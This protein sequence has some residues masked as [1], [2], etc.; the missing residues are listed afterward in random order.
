MA[1]SDGISIVDAFTRDDE[2]PMTDWSSLVGG[3]AVVS[4]EAEPTDSGQNLV[5]YDDDTFGPDVEVFIQ[6]ED[7]PSANDSLGLV[8]GI[9]SGSDGYMLHWIVRSGTDELEIYRL[10]GGSPTQ[11]SGDVADEY[12]QFEGLGLKLTD[13]NPEAWRNDGGG[14]D[15]IATRT[16]G[17]HDAVAWC[18]MYGWDASGTVDDFSAG[19]PAAA[20]PQTVTV[21]DI[22]SA[23][24]FGAPTI[25][26]GAVTIVAPGIATAE[27]MGAPTITV[28]AATINPP[29]IA[30]AEA[31]G[32]P[33]ISTGAVTVVVP[34]I[35][36]A[37]AIG[38]PTISATNTINPPG[39]A[40]AEAFGA[41]T[42]TTGVATVNPPGITSDEAIGAPTITTGGVTVN[43][44]GIATAEA[45]GAPTVATSAQAVVVDGIATGE[46]IGAPTITPGA[47]TVNPPGI[48]SA[49][50]IGAPTISTGAVTVSPAGI[51]TA[52]ATGE[53]TISATATINPPGIA[54]DEAIGAPTITTGSVTV[55]PAGI[56]SAEAIGAPTVGGG[57]SVA[58]E[59][60][61]TAEATGAV[62]ITIG[63]APVNPVGIASSETMG[64]P[65]VDV[66]VGP[67]VAGP[68][69]WDVLADFEEGDYSDFTGS[70]QSWDQEESF[71]SPGNPP[72]GW[73]WSNGWDDYLD[74]EEADLTDFD[75]TTDTGGSLNAAGDVREGVYGMGFV[76][77]DAGVAYGDKNLAAVNQTSFITA[78]SLKVD[79]GFAS[80]VS[81]NTWVFGAYDGAGQS[82]ALMSIYNDGGTYKFR[83]T[84]RNDSDGTHTLTDYTPTPGTFYDFI[85]TWI[86]GDGTGQMKVYINGALHTFK[87]DVDNDTK[88]VDLTRWGKVFTTSAVTFGGKVSFD[89]IYHH[90]GIRAGVVA[91]RGSNIG[92]DGIFSA[93]LHSDS[94]ETDVYLANT[95][96]NSGANGGWNYEFRINTSGWTSAVDDVQF[97][98]VAVDGTG[99]VSYIALRNVAGQLKLQAGVKDDADAVAGLVTSAVLGS[100]TYH[101]RVAV[102]TS[103]GSND[104][105]TYMWINGAYVG[106]V[107]GVDNDERRFQE[108]RVGA[109][110]NDA[111]QSRNIKLD[112]LKWNDVEDA[113]VHV[114]AGAALSGNY[115]MMLPVNGLS[116][117]NIWGTLTPTNDTKN[118]TTFEIDPNSVTMSNGDDFIVCRITGTSSM[119]TDVKLGYDSSSYNL[120]VVYYEDT[121]G[122]ITSSSTNITDA[123][124]TVR[125]VQQVASSDGADDGFMQM[126]ID[127][128][129]AVS[130]MDLNTDTQDIDT[131]QYGLV[132]EQ[133]AGTYGAVYMDD[134]GYDTDLWYHQFRGTQ[135]NTGA[136]ARV[137][138]FVRALAGSQTNT[139]I[140]YRGLQRAAE[141]FAG[142]LTFVGEN[143]RV[144]VFPRTIMT[145]ALTF[146]G[147]V[148]Q[149]Y[150]RIVL[151]ISRDEFMDVDVA[152]D[153]LVDVAIAG[154]EMEGRL[155]VVVVNSMILKTDVENMEE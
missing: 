84:V 78:F 138:S 127:H 139:G 15:Q 66:G 21:E 39:I 83:F 58:V 106:R 45:I 137:V 18:G 57:V 120:H 143:V 149:V 52:E 146:L 133:D 116:T 77:D 100:G 1:F 8:A 85:I 47:A 72:S 86:A 46:A 118:I 145:G 130:A 67:T 28:G 48:A 154:P 59:G 124:H 81:S 41:P 93:I 23:E 55:S 144:Y 4:N 65:A 35:A 102:K 117:T 60:I 95:S 51:A 14:W 63:A 151:K 33:T 12:A 125:I 70:V 111:S 87:I 97:P 3:F 61:A 50:A 150:N 42:I 26:T 68:G 30:S 129:L 62:T 153:M 13:G 71:E 98:L 36:T 109:M 131:V 2:D 20:G 134:C 79:S 74:F 22:V 69:T 64:A 88:D 101:V 80:D 6:V 17:N 11:L 140:I 37:E 27:A 119:S 155:D 147:I 10:D 16:D 148:T 108:L 89:E 136:W 110:N 24:A 113:P 32:A 112:D 5:Y 122:S 135:T 121:G 90:G 103:T 141:V 123:A 49:E 38:A 115:G 82:Q 99:I 54:P 94:E 29:G 104:G 56:A 92:H 76:M 44:A 43:P 91:Q 7:Y 53:P 40:P 114:T 128:V 73:S 19:E 107:T 75:S 25:S 152:T 132:T 105:N 31:I 126:Y 96:P 9:T 142:A 34:G